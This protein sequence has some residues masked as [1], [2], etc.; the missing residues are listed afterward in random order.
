MIEKVAEV[1]LKLKLTFQNFNLIFSESTSFTVTR[2]TSPFFSVFITFILFLYLSNVVTLVTCPK[3]L[4]SLR[5]LQLSSSSGLVNTQTELT[6][7]EPSDSSYNLHHGL[8][9]LASRVETNIF[10]LYGRIPSNDW[11]N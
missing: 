5:L 7:L 3:A 6:G 4:E 9:S 8:P 2:I 1:V 10:L 11:V